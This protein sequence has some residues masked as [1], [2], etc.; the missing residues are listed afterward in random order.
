ML[1]QIKILTGLKF[2]ALHQIEVKVCAKFKEWANKAVFH[3]FLTCLSRIKVYKAV[4][5]A[6]L[7]TSHRKIK[8]KIKSGFSSLKNSHAKKFNFCVIWIKEDKGF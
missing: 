8:R 2:K 1:S 3:L 4:A 5:L 6:G 7:L